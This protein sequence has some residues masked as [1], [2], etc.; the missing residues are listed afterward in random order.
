VYT[1]LTNDN[2]SS[3]DVSKARRTKFMPQKQTQYLHTPQ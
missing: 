3:T 1:V 2:T